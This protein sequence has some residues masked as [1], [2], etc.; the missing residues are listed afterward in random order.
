MFIAGARACECARAHPSCVGAR[1]VREAASHQPWECALRRQLRVVDHSQASCRRPVGCGECG[2]ANV[3]GTENEGTSWHHAWYS[4]HCVHA[5]KCVAVERALMFTSSAPQGAPNK[6]TC[7]PTPL[8]L[9]SA[10]Y[11]GCG[12]GVAD[13]PLTRGLVA[14]FPL[15]KDALLVPD[16]MRSGDCPAPYPLPR[17]MCAAP[18]P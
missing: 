11:H 15:L 16:T 9:N 13:P 2:T 8:L 7:Q 14:A 10:R 6:N 1:L 4:G 12:F 3:V 5:V 18:A 17:R